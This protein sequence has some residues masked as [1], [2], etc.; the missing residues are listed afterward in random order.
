MKKYFPFLSLFAFVALQSCGEYDEQGHRCCFDYTYQ[1]TIDVYYTA[2]ELRARS[3][4][5]F[6]PAQPLQSPGKIFWIGKTLLISEKQKGVHIINN[7]DPKN[8]VATGFVRIP[9]NVDIATN[10]R[11]LIADSYHDLLVLELNEKRLVSRY[12]DVIPDWQV[13]QQAEADGLKHLLVKERKLET[14]TAKAYCGACEIMEMP[15]ARGASQSGKGGSMARFAL[16]GDTLYTLTTHQLQQFVLDNAGQLVLRAELNLEKDVVEA[17]TIFADG[18][19][20][21]IGSTTGMAIVEINEVDGLELISVV[22]HFV[23]CD[24]VVVEGDYAFVTLHSSKNE[25]TRT[26]RCGMRSQDVLQVYDISDKKH[27]EMLMEQF[28][29]NPH[30]LGVSGDKIYVCEGDKGLKILEISDWEKIHLSVEF[31]TLYTD[32]SFHAYDV[33]VEPEQ[34]ILFLVGK[35]GLRQYRLKDQELLSIIPI[36]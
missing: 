30:G 31:P 10:G 1:D 18:N 3:S 26:R 4:I 27:P 32:E 24:P 11:F 28:L 6:L 33:I 36:Q 7:N 29:Y 23:S 19:Y 12:N 2:E 8:P 20:L 5:E 16:K 22:D 34:G 35:D 13:F 15:S 21:Y 25:I 14:F 9:G 17:E